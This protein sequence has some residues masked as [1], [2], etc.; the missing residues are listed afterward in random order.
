[1]FLVLCRDVLERAAWQA[2]GWRSL[3]AG[4][5]GPVEFE[6]ES[7]NVVNCES[8]RDLLPIGPALVK[9]TFGSIRS[10]KAEMLCSQNWIDHM[11]CHKQG[12]VESYEHIYEPL[13]QLDVPA[14]V[15]AEVLA[16]FQ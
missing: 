7:V 8:F 16:M 11:K 12:T 4:L 5:H 14:R 10:S 1:L 15:W 3:L 9:A 2:K 13:K 6:S